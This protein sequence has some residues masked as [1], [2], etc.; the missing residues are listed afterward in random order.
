[1]DDVPGM[2]LRI[3]GIAVLLAAAP[4][5]QARMCP[6][7]ATVAEENELFSD[8]DIERWGNY[9]LKAEGIYDK[10]SPCMIHVAVTTVQLKGTKTWAASVNITEMSRLSKTLWVVGARDIRVIIFGELVTASVGTDIREILERFISEKTVQTED[11]S[12]SKEASAN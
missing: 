1:M 8:T 10:S 3:V 11:L 6:T 4:R 7:Y 12:S 5:V 9:A 2:I